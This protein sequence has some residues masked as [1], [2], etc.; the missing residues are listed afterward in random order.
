MEPR[1]PHEWSYPLH[2]LSFA[3]VSMSS[4]LAPKV[5]QFELLQKI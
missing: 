4:R 2:K 5:D 3:R 1:G